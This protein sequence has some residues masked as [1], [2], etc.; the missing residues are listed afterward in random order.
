MRRWRRSSTGCRDA[1]RCA[2]CWRKS[3]ASTAAA[4]CR[5]CT[6]TTS[7]AGSAAIRQRRPPDARARVL[8]LDDC[9]TTFNE[10]GI[11]RAAV[12]VLEQA[13]YAVEL[14]GLICC[15]RPMISKGFLRTARALIQAQLPRALRAPRRRHAAPGPGAELPADAGRRVARAGAGCRHAGTSPRPPI[16]PTTGW[17]S[18][19]RPDAASWTLKARPEKCLLHGHCHQ[20]A[21]LG[22][23]ASAALLGLVPGLDVT[24]LDTGCCG[25]AGSFGF[26]KEHYDLSV[27]IAELALLPALTAEPEALVVAPGTSCRHQIKDLAGRRALH[28]LEVVESCLEC[29]VR[30]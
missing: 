17:P 4:A 13:G 20:K 29:Q 25:M 28:P 5:R 3:P 19:H 16:W 2:G 30:V 12:R 11:G 23:R 6:P 26:E 14:A 27:A 1:V 18:R 8:L 22:V 21:L 10:P 15:G 9:F 24:V 7:A